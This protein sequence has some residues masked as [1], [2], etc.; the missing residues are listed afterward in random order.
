MIRI[1]I[2]IS[3][4]LSGCRSTGEAEPQK[5]STQPNASP[6]AAPSAPDRIP[7]EPTFPRGVSKGSAVQNTTAAPAPPVSMLLPNETVV[8]S[9]KTKTGKTMN[10]VLDKEQRYLA[11]RYGT[12]DRVELQFPPVLENTFSQFTYS[13]YMRGGGPENEGVDLNRLVFTGAANRFTVYSER[14]YEDGKEINRIG[15]RVTNLKTGK[16]SD[17]PGRIQTVKGSLLDFRPGWD[18]GELVVHEEI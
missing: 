6:A 15:I 16:E 12:K 11:Y 2:A 4:A 3:L 17:I 8:F 7:E 9:F 18:L 10:I 13:Y 14:H 5:T 1:I